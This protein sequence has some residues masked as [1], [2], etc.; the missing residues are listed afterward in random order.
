VEDRKLWSKPVDGATI[1]LAGAAQIFRID[2][3]TDYLRRGQVIKTTNDSR[4]GVS[5]LGP[6]EADQQTVLN[7]VRGYWGIETQQHYRRDYTQREDHCHVRNSTSARNL[8]LMRSLAI[9]L[10]ELQRRRRGG[11]RSLPDWQAKNHRDPNP[12]IGLLSAGAP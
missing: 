4:Y 5:S 6:D 9:F 2:T 11:K 8:S 10:Y 1:G 3:K 7:L 12:L